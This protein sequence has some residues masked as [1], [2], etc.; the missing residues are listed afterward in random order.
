MPESTS[1]LLGCNIQSLPTDRVDPVISSGSR[2]SLTESDQSQLQ[3][4]PDPAGESSQDSAAIPAEQKLT[5]NGDVHLENENVSSTNSQDTERS[6]PA[7][8]NVPS[9][10]VDSLRTESH[11]ES[12]SHG[13]EAPTSGS[14]SPQV[15]DVKPA[16]AS[17]DKDS[18]DDEDEEQDDEAEESSDDA[19]SGSDVDFDERRRRN[20]QAN[21]DFLQQHG[22]QQVNCWF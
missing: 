2:A 17:T 8:S 7:P 4:D 16:D 9:T 13:S 22:L 11:P 10:A 18:S 3:S 1:A 21:L 15:N 5:L 20:I 6:S 14:P 12:L 19:G